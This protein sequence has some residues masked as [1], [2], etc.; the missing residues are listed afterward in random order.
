VKPGP[1]QCKCS[2]G[3]LPFVALASFN[4]NTRHAYGA[5][6]SDNP[7]SVHAAPPHSGERAEIVLLYESGLASRAV[8]EQLG[9]SKGCVM[10]ILKAEGVM[11]RRGGIRVIHGNSDGGMGRGKTAHP[12]EE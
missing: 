10:C 5:Y 12:F 2:G 7:A 11:M 3:G 9:V 4:P 6:R 1:D 8:A